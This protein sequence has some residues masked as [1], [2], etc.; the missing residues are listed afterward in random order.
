MDLWLLTFEFQQSM[1]KPH[2]LRMISGMKYS[3][4]E[5]IETNELIVL[6]L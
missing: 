1:D 4:N 5:S 2:T 3:W 6:L